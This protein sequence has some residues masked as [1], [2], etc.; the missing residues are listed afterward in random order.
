ML[1]QYSNFFFFPRADC[2]ARGLDPF[3]DSRGELV[4]LIVRKDLL[5]VRGMR[6][7]GFVPSSVF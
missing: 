3:H 2:N 7:P 1:L 6:V 4:L 5:G